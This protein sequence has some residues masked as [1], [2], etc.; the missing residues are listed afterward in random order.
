MVSDGLG[1]SPLFDNGCEPLHWWWHKRKIAAL[2]RLHDQ[3]HILP[4]QH[5]QKLMCG[6]EIEWVSRQALLFRPTN[7][8]DDQ[9]IWWL[10]VLVSSTAT[11]TMKL[12]RCQSRKTLSAS[13]QPNLMPLWSMHNL[14]VSARLSIQRETNQIKLNKTQL[15]SENERATYNCTANLTIP[16]DLWKN[17]LD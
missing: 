15:N 14:K 9:P 8:A 1:K 12:F 11:A 13:L 10:D 7:S 5:N 17:Y 6:L 3:Q 2:Q 16:Q 4:T